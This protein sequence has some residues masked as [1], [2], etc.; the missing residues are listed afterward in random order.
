MITSF[1]SWLSRLVDDMWAVAALAGVALIIAGFI[2][3]QHHDDLRPAYTS[4]RWAA[5]AWLL[6]FILLWL[7]YRPL[8]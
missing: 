8:L 6:A 5:L 1:T 3:R 2:Q 4:M 7:K